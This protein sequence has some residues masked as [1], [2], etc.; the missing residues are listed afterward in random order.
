MTWKP[1]DT[2][3]TGQWVLVSSPDFDGEVEVAIQRLGHIPAYDEQRRCVGE[4][5][6]LDW[7]DRGGYHVRPD[8][9]EPLIGT[10]H[11][12]SN[13]AALGAV[14]AMVAASHVRT[15]E[16]SWL[17]ECGASPYG[18]NSPHRCVYC[19]DEVQP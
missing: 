2:A 4:R 14:V 8:E 15:R 5:Y 13:M 10:C 3:P 17:L 11:R 1:I 18:E 16:F 9:W 6:G 12:A 7:F 19:D